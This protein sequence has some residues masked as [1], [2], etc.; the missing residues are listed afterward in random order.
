MTAQPTLT[1]EQRAELAAFEERPLSPEAFAERVAAPWTE[2]ERADFV[3]LIEW[4]QRR[5]P[6]PLERLQATRHL[7]AQWER[8]R[9]R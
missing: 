2:D 4:F 3:A 8:N 6:T 5:Y 1:P 9:P 7:A